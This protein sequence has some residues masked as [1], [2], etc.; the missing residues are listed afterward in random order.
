MAHILFTRVFYKAKSPVNG[1]EIEGVR[2]KSKVNCLLN[3]NTVDRR[4]TEYFYSFCFTNIDLAECFQYNSV[5]PGIVGK[6]KQRSL[7][8][9]FHY[10]D[11]KQIGK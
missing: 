4:Y 3:C 1:A 9:E 6:K 8:L 11:E 10:T 5:M 7:T 2:G